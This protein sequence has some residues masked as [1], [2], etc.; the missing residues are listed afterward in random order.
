M[1]NAMVLLAEGFEEVEALT[2]VDVLRRGGV[3]VTM[4]A[5]GDALEVL[6]AH[7]IRVMADALFAGVSGEEFDALVLPGGGAGTE[8]LRSNTRVLERIR[9][10]KS[11][12]RL[13]CAICA[14]PLVLVDAQVLE[15]QQHVTCYPTCVMDL[16]RPC[17][18]VPVV[19]D[20]N[21]ITGQAPGAAML[22]GL[23]ILQHLMGDPVAHKVA[24]GLVTDVLD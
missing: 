1:A 16:D 22:F 17:A 18:S 7:G 12:G 20:D 14:A 23:V 3:K 10:Q 5:V 11:E 4:A 21:V 24:R 19:V 15:D 9:R 6:G 2:V 8:N 13:I